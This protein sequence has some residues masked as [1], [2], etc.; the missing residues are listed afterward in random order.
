MRS[1]LCW[2]LWDVVNSIDRESNAFYLEGLWQLE[3]IT[4]PLLEAFVKKFIEIE[5]AIPTAETC[6][7]LAGRLKQLA[8][9]VEEENKREQ[10]KVI[11]ELQDKISNQFDEFMLFSKL[12]PELRRRIWGFALPSGPRVVELYARVRGSE[13]WIDFRRAA[14]TDLIPLMKACSESYDA[15]KSRYRVVD[16]NSLGLYS[17]NTSSVVLLDP[18]GDT[19]YMSRLIHALFVGDDEYDWY[20]QS[21]LALQEF[22]S[23][24]FDERDFA[25][26]SNSPTNSLETIVLSKMTKLKKIILIHNLGR[27][28]WMMT[29]PYL[30]LPVKIIP[31]QSAPQLSFTDARDNWYRKVNSHTEME[32]LRNVTI[33]FATL[34]REFRPPLL[35]SRLWTRFLEV[36]HLELVTFSSGS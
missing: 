10:A 2:A 27:G 24:A 1:Q 21:L 36:R 8:E 20:R 12:P 35:T 17:S 31:R 14:Q 23:I 22:E 25:M 29:E 5:G 7:E 28:D 32:G 11:E 15:V 30:E 34:K 26:C 18:L 9:E 19:V 3:L 13:S 33:E 16:K 4:E 6:F